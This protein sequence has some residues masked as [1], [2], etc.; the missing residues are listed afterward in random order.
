MFSKLKRI[1]DIVYLRILAKMPLPLRN[2]ILR[3]MTSIPD[4]SRHYDTISLYDEHL[5]IKPEIRNSIVESQGNILHK[6]K[7]VK[8]WMTGVHSIIGLNKTRRITL[9]DY[10]YVTLNG[11]YN[12]ESLLIS[13]T[14]VERDNFLYIDYKEFE[15]ED[16]RYYAFR[17]GSRL[18]VSE[19]LI[20]WDEIYSGKRGIKNSMLFVKRDEDVVLVFIEYTPGTIRERHHILE[21]SFTRKTVR[22]AKEFFTYGEYLENKELPCCRH[23]HVIDKDPFTNDIYV[24]TGDNDIES[25][26]WVSKDNGRSYELLYRNG[27][28]SRTLSFMFTQNYVFWTMDSHEP[29]FIVRLKRNTKET[30][31]YPIVN[32]A[33]WHSFRLYKDGKYYYVIGSNSEGAHYDNNNRVY[34]ISLDD[35][36]PSVYELTCCKSKTQYDQ[37]FP[38]FARNNEVY[39]YDIVGCCIRQGIVD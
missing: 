33:L 16:Y 36:M 2:S 13:F 26:I 29:Q 15:V 28:L 20:D 19:N 24:G 39:L 31:L 38:V 37:L 27:Q 6:G 1:I 10:L 18:F 22:V 35:E 21:Y 14:P 11:L 30:D 3:F 23:I 4:N 34:G 32:G 9:N 12:K 25:A 17:T 7:L 5:Q 8:C